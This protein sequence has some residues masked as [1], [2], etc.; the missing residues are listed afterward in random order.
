MPEPEWSKDVDLEAGPRDKKCVDRP[1][2]DR[3]DAEKCTGKRQGTCG[4]DIQPDDRNNEA[5]TAA[6]AAAA[7]ANIAKTL[8]TLAIAAAVAATAFF[9]RVKYSIPIP[10]W[11]GPW[12]ASKRASWRWRWRWTCLGE[13]LTTSEKV[14][15]VFV[16]VFFGACAAAFVRSAFLEPDADFVDDGSQWL[17]F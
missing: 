1:D 3:H 11:L 13:P 16:A 12:L 17:G 7:S 15:I 6:P 9:I 4:R 2:L 14:S 8:T 10:R 5:R